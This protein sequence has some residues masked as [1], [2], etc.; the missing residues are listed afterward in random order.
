ML[1]RIFSPEG[2][3]D[4]ALKDYTFRSSQLEMA[5]L[6]QEGFNEGKDIVVEAGTGTGKSFAYLVP[7][8]LKLA[9]DQSSKIVIATST[10]TL[11][12]Q[13]YEKDIPI[14]SKALNIDLPIAILYGR[15]NYV[16]Q[17]R[18]FEQKEERKLLF[19]N[20]ESPEGKLDAWFQETRSGAIQD[21]PPSCIRAMNDVMC[22]EHDCLSRQ[23]PYA[24]Q[25]FFF[26]ARANAKKASLIVT[27]HHLVLI[28]ARLRRETE[29]TFE[30]ECI[31]PPYN[32]LVVDEAHHIQDEATDI[33][34]SIF[35]TYSAGR[36]LDELTKKRRRFGAMSLV[37]FLAPHETPE[38]RAEHSR[39]KTMVDVLKDYL[40]S[41]DDEI[42]TLLGKNHDYLF[43]EEFYSRYRDRIRFASALALELRN[44]GLYISSNYNPLDDEPNI[45]VAKHYARDLIC[46]SDVIRDWIDFNSFDELISYAEE[47]S[48]TGKY[49]IKLSPMSTGPVLYDYLISNLKSVL[50]CSATLTVEDRFEYFAENCG[51]AL[52]SSYLHGIFESPFEYGKSLMILSPLDGMEF[53]Q[54]NKVGFYGYS[55]K[56]IAEAIESSGGG[57]LVLFTANEMLNEVCSKVRDMIG[58][59]YEILCQSDKGSRH[60]LLNRFKESEN[61]S[62][63][64]TTSFWEGVDAPG[65]TLRLVIIA[66]LPFQVPTDPIDMARSHYIESHGLGS[67][68][69]N[70]TIPKASI[71]LKQGIG[72][73]IRSE[74]DRGVVL[75]LDARI[76]KKNYGRIMFKSIPHGYIP[77]DTLVDNIPSKIERFLFS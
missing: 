3:L 9:E 67:G 31:L 57:A 19:L 54:G 56:V 41:F 22:D 71:K 13:L 66:K 34:S 11:Q 75:I 62:L 6:V 16:C 40:A 45:D 46:Y 59:D 61:S 48:K 33:L 76:I 32:Y 1:D 35:N 55:A 2:E 42:N 74:N 58:D 39:I 50:Y 10:T 25:C 14:I 8:F 65:N 36:T 64:A 52:A 12:K 5:R 27:N 43:T 60:M 44:F 70:L 38:R 68:F 20:P 37:D 47:D 4:C 72:R 63:F 17:R 7:S 18:Y 30:E 26:R 29:K 28:D 69:M 77:E 49:T 24:N 51:L 23:C 15:G 21:A 73:L 53:S